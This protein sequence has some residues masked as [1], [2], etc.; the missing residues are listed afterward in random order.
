MTEFQILGKT[1]LEQLF[2]KY[3]FTGFF[4]TFHELK[5]RLQIE[6]SH[7]NRLMILNVL[8][9]KTLKR[10]EYIQ[11]L[12]ELVSTKHANEPIS[13]Q[14]SFVRSLV[15]ARHRLPDEPWQIFYGMVWRIIFQS[16]EHALR[17]RP[18]RYTHTQYF[19]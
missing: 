17:G 2:D 9:S 11:A 7:Q 13:V 14:A 16:E 3:R 5:K 4:Q 8:V 19:K 1:L 6:N 18:S 12:L 10:A 15:R